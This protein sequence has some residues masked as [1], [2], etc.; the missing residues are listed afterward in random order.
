MPPPTHPPLRRAYTSN[1]TT[2]ARLTCCR[3]AH[4]LEQRCG[5]S[6]A[7]LSALPI[8]VDCCP[9][10]GLCIRSRGKLCAL[11]LGLRLLLFSRVSWLS[12]CKGL[13]LPL[14]SNPGHAR[15]REGLRQCKH[16]T[17]PGWRYLG[18]ASGKGGCSAGVV[19]LHLPSGIGALAETGPKFGLDIDTPLLH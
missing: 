18:E 19:A 5:G 15:P 2:L 16:R 4:G 13:A 3:G 12:F 6:R 8:S 17:H 7:L 14:W 1:P 9:R 10:R 11:C